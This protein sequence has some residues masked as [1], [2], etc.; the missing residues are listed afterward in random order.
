MEQIDYKR[1]KMFEVPMDQ[2]N[3]ETFKKSEEQTR[4]E[5]TEIWNQVKEGTSLSEIN[6][7]IIKQNCEEMFGLDVTYRKNYL[8]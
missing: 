8:L 5:H 6:Q 7:I 2:N 4:R 3:P 1:K